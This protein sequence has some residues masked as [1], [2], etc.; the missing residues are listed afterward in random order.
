VFD[1]LNA[2][3]PIFTIVKALLNFFKGKTFTV[4]MSGDLLITLMLSLQRFDMVFKDLKKDYD[5]RV[6]AGLLMEMAPDEAAK[7][8]E[9]YDGDN[10]GTMS[11]DEIE[12]WVT[13]KNQTAMLQRERIVQG[14]KDAQEKKQA[15]KAKP[16][17]NKITVKGEISLSVV[18]VAD[19]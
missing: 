6:G 17:A 2:M 11:M 10:S 13:E 18:G 5:E 9:K 15:V 1:P 4:V 8:L 19:S 14:L 16:R 7:A 3:V 12:K